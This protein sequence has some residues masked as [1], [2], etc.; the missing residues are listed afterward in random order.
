MQIYIGIIMTQPFITTVTKEWLDNF[1]IK[2]K[3]CHPYFIEL[4]IAAE[5]GKTKQNSPF[6]DLFPKRADFL[7]FLKNLKEW[8]YYDLIM[9]ADGSDAW[10]EV[11]A[12]QM[13]YV[14]EFSFPVFKNQQ[15]LLQERAEFRED[16]YID[17]DIPLFDDV[18]KMM[19]L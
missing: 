5:L 12:I 10:S 19:R 14:E 13:G 18:K 8:G 3:N 2:I 7:K 11:T 15:F 16:G 4:D 9:K 17:S 1:C 6:A